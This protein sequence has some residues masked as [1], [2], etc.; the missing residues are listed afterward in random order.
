MK[1]VDEASIWVAA[2]NGGNGSA[3][4]RREKYI[5]FGGPDGGD[6]GRGGSVFLVADSGMNTL[7]DFRVGRKYKAKPGDNGSGRNCTGRSGSDLEIVVPVGTYVY[8]DDTDELI[9][10]ITDHAQRLLVAQ[11][12]V[13]GL[14]NTRFKSS[15]NRAPKKTTPGSVG[16]KRKL[17]L[18]LKVLADVGLLGYPNAGKST[19]IRSMSAAKPKVADYPFT[20]LIPNLGVVRVDESRSFVMA[21]I[22][23]LIEG[24]AD[25]AGL[26]HQFL[27]HLERT[28]LLLHVVDLAPLY[29]DTDIAAEAF[30]LVKE[31]EKYSDELTEKERWFVFNK[32]DM[33]DEVTFN[34][35][36]QS[37]LDAF[38]GENRVFYISALA[39]QGLDELKYAVMEYMD[40]VV[41]NE[42]N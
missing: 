15:V 19:L 1:F 37:V 7:A 41:E 5:E 26:G 12:G 38:D 21:D 24:A 13:G 16:E 22:P 23:G 18:E 39:K 8:D 36:A 25:G 34:A 17:R 20:T 11:G 31:L 29:E 10:D 3:S 32:Q 27:K 9:G 4:F 30:A 42:D 33:V 6:G 14:G 35:R 40:G 28:R 2:G